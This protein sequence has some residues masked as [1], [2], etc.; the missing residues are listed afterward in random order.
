[1]PGDLQTQLVP[2]DFGIEC[3][4]IHRWR[5]HTVPHRQHG[6]QQ[7]GHPGGFQRVPD[8]PFGAADRQFVTPLSERPEDFIQG[9]E[10]GR[11]TN[12]RAGRVGF[13]ILHGGGLQVGRIG[14]ANRFDLPFLPRCP[15]AFAFAI[16]GDSHAADDCPNGIAIALRGGHRFQHQGHVTFR[17]DQ[18][19]RTVVEGTAAGGA[20]RFGFAE[21]HQ[22]VEFTVAR[23]A[24]DRAI[25][26][27]ALQGADAHRHGN[28]ARRASRV[29]GHRGTFPA[30]RAGNQRSDIVGI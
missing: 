28:Q 12:L 27:A 9:R 16:A 1:M 18:P 4:Q 5:D 7:T 8:V 22:G 14:A 13:E 29:D 19:V 10:F 24:H 17:R 6:F 23:S 3:L 30:E 25:Q 20:G 15:E 11:V 26:L 2:L 21:Q